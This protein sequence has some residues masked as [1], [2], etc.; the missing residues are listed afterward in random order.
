MIQ[1]PKSYNL[2][3]YTV[4]FG[5]HLIFVLPYI[6]SALYHNNTAI[7]ETV[8]GNTE[9]LT[10]RAKEYLNYYFKGRWLVRQ[11]SNRFESWR[12]PQKKSIRWI[13]VPRIKTLYTYIGDIDILVLDKEIYK[14]HV[15]HANEIGLPY[16]NIV[17]STG[18]KLT[19]LHFVITKPY[20]SKLNRKYR[21]KIIKKI[22]QN[23]FAKRLDER[24]LYIMVKQQIGVEGARGIRPVHGI[25][26]SLNRGLVGWGVTLDRYNRYQDFSKTEV[27]KEGL[28]IFH[29]EYVG[30]LGRFDEAFRLQNIKGEFK[31]QLHET[32]N[33]KARHKIITKIKKLKKI[34]HHTGKI[35]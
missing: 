21:M 28:K 20:Y 5:P 7:A 12:L 35:P 25:H 6:V 23:K 15:E 11:L 33:K 29:K 27:W 34:K 18:L 10:K 4:A 24:L 17:R 1:Q 3:F 8:V 26:M 19:G 2:N 9:I 31:R 13:T 14:V 30:M 32:N 22:E 16:S